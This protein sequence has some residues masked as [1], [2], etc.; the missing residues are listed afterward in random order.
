VD[1]L[2]AVQHLST[3]DAK[4]LAEIPVEF[5][6]VHDGH[7]NHHTHYTLELEDAK[8][9]NARVSVD[10]TVT[11]V[12][13]LVKHVNYAPPFQAPLPISTPT[14]FFSAI[15]RFANLLDEP[16]ARWSHRLIPGEAFI[17]DNRRVMHARSAFADASPGQREGRWLKGCYIQGDALADRRRVLMSQLGLAFPE[18]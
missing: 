1:G 7:H 13:P 16:G 10:S 6:Y 5:H 4:V 18:E 17:F 9:I 14:P 3:E 2:R 12:R 11:D 15:R 8:K